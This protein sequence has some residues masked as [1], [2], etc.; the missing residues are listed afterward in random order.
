MAIIGIG[1]DIIEIKRIAKLIEQTSDTFIQRLFTPFEQAEAA[2]YQFEK[3][4]A[5]YAKRFAAKEAFSKA[6]GYG[7]GS[8]A[9]WQ[10][11]EIRNDSNG[12]PF[13]QITG[14]ALKTLS[15]KT[16]TFRIHLS[17]SDDQQAVAFVVIED[18]SAKRDS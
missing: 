17:L 13:F 12:T 2:K 15:E 4:V 6:L 7:I 14:T 10:D 16:T 11:I 8:K 18:I 3:R 1:T 9:F 5:F